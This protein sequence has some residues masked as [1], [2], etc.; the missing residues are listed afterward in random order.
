MLSIHF[1][2]IGF[3]VDILRKRLDSNDAFV[4]YT[5]LT[6]IFNLAYIYIYIYKVRTI[7]FQTYF[8]WKLSLIVNTWNS[9]SVR[10]NLL[11]RQFIVQPFQQLLQGPMEV[12]LGEPV[13]DLRHSLFHLLNCLLTTASE[14]R[15][16]AS[17]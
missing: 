16:L 12:L 4:C 7:I 10:S 17:H 11:R 3:F 8:V 5:Y 9:S 6:L 2:N 15:V 13:N 1:S 14:L